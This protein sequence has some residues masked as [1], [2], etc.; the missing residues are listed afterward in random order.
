MN[1]ALQRKEM[2]PQIVLGMSNL[3]IT[4]YRCYRK[5]CFWWKNS[6]SGTEQPPRQ[7]CKVG[8]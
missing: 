8:R 3:C 1:E 6:A 2:H 5:P 7:C 4:L